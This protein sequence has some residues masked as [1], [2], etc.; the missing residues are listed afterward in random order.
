MAETTKS[1]IAIEKTSDLTRLPELGESILEF[2]FSN[3]IA[4]LRQE[5]SWQRGTG[6]SSKTLVKH[7]SFRVVLTLLKA[8]VSIHEHRTDAPISIQPVMGKI[9][10]HLPGRTAELAQGHL[11]VLD[12]DVPHDVEAIEESAFLLTIG[13]HR[14][15][16]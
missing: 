10:L 6:R 12:S 3:E 15:A 16:K 5:D 9:R 7:P 14:T 2:D 13:W 4:R 8:N 11:L 1:Q